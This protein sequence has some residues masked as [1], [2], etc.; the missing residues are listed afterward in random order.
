MSD[1]VYFGAVY[2]RKTN[3]PRADWERDHG[4]AAEDGHTLFRHWVS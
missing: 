3:P 1:Q 2:F 4:V